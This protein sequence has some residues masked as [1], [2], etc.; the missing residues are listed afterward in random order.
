MSHSQGSGVLSCANVLPPGSDSAGWIIGESTP[1]RSMILFKPQVKPR[2]GM[3][4]LVETSEGCVLGIVERVLSGHAILGD[5]IREAEEL[6][7]ITRYPDFRDKIYR[8]GIVQWVSLLD[9]LLKARVRSPSTPPDPGA[10]AY[11][12]PGSVLQAAF[13][14]SGQEWIPIGHLVS[15][16]SVTV[17]VNVNRLTRHLAILAV[18]GGGKSNTVCV[19]AKRIVGSLNGTMVVFDIHGEY[20]LARPPL[21]GD[22]LT[23]VK[24][25]VI[26][27]FA[28]SFPELR[29]LARIPDNAHVQERILREAWKKLME[30]WRK[31]N[32]AGKLSQKKGFLELLKTYASA[33]GGKYKDSLLGLLNRLDD[34]EDYYGNV[35]DSSAPPRL[36]DYIEP[37]KLNIIDLSN[38]DEYAADAVVSH[39]LRRLLEERKQWK[40]T[41]GQK[42]YPVPVLAV[43]EEAHVL[44][45]SKDDTL[46]KYWAARVAREGRKFGVG[47]I[48]VSQRPKNVDQ[49]VLSQTNNKIILRI[50]EPQ[51]Q[52]YVQAASEQLSEDLMTLLPSLNPGEAIILGGM[53]RIPAMVKIDKC[54][55]QT[56]GADIDIVREW[57][58]GS[59]P[60]PEGEEDLEE[61]SELF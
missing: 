49:D 9:P 27:P 34:M 21:A 46:T 1:S 26:K 14:G 60:K 32:L 48:L 36:E 41:G 56:G 5:K 11:T 30:D 22:K 55:V 25:P 40:A 33:V 58:S 37:G 54:P 3:Y 6:Q 61:V 13:Q 19:L 15:D 16:P 7:A 51:D 47:L 23:S 52:R 42:G 45:P 10:E 57:M 29:K 28:L 39:Y 4:L 17:S 31:G 12:A 35:I 50:V 18:T 24:Q 20:A 44:I 43:V 59:Q 8:V 2:N 38:V 53:T